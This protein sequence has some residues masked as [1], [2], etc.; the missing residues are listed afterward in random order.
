[1][2]MQTSFFGE[3]V[4]VSN[5]VPAETLEALEAGWYVAVLTKANV[6]L[7]DYGL[8][9]KL[10]FKV[11]E[12]PA[13]GKTFFD[14]SFIITHKNS[15][16]AHDIAQRRL[17]SWCD[18]VGIEPNIAGLDVF[19]GKTVRVK[20]RREEGRQ[21][22]GKSYGP[23][24]RIEAFAAHDGRPLESAAQPSQVLRSATA[25]A[26]TAAAPAQPAAAAA[27]AAGTAPAAKR[28]PWQKS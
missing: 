20:L 18:A 5:V 21:Y 7:K 24:N 28:M 1:M 13:A 9:S 12:G 2:D 15:A 27:P 19:L 16:Q 14:N 23:S 10:Q 17:R 3:T 11:A 6:Q 22:E 4:N 25:P 8:T 26:S